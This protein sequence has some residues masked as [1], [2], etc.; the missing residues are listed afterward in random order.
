[1]W[2]CCWAL[3]F[4]NAGGVRSVPPEAMTVEIVPSNEAPQIET[5][6]IE[7]PQI[8]TRQVEGTPLDLTSVGSEV[9]SDSEKG[10]ATAELAPAQIGRTV[11]ATS[12]SP[13]GPAAQRQPGGPQSRRPQRPYSL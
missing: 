3:L 12:T 5:P 2:A 1:M 4:F 8:E 9:S 11:A 6:Q 13:F 10:S 7:T